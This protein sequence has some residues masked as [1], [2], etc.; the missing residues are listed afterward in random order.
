[1]Q[2]DNIRF[3]AFY[4]NPGW[5][6]HVRKIRK[7]YTVKFEKAASIA[8]SPNYWIVG[9]VSIEA[10]R[11]LCSRAIALIELGRDAYYTY[12]KSANSGWL[13]HITI[14][15]DVLAYI[16]ATDR[17][18]NRWNRFGGVNSPFLTGDANLVE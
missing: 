16:N 3:R 7:K 10:A 6:A 18:T 1:M 11:S 9:D 2:V 12:P 14:W 15:S 5:H 8:S 17:K 4:Q 13:S